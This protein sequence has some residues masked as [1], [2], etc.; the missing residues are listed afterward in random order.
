MF[1][2]ETIK[3]LSLKV[4][5]FRGACGSKYVFR[6][7]TLWQFWSSSFAELVDLNLVLASIRPYGAT[8]KLFRG[9]CGSKYNTPLDIDAHEPSSSFA[10]LVDLNNICLT[11][12]VYCIT[13][14]SFAELVDLN[15]TAH[16]WP[17]NTIVKL[18]RGACGSKFQ[19]FNIT[20]WLFQRQ[21]LSRSLWI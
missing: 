14:S 9:A 17:V 3:P 15:T 13:S 12:I 16:Q 11:I 4:K 18:F 5:L 10:E 21:A 7:F 20:C 8:V 6:N 1:E 2:V 19:P